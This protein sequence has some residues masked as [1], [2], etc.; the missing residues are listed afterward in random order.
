MSLLPAANTDG[1]AMCSGS[2][3]PLGRNSSFPYLSYLQAGGGGD[4]IGFS[5][6]FHLELKTP[7]ELN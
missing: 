7:I 4:L 6:R 1:E 2:C 3:L 5:A